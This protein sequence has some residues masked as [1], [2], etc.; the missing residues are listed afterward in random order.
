MAQLGMLF[1]MG[2]LFALSY[3]WTGSLFAPVLLHSLNNVYALLQG[4]LQHQGAA[5]IGWPAI[6]L[7]VVSPLIAFAILYVLMRVLP[8]KKIGI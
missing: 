2:V 5:P 7:A 3:E 6:V 4:V 8:R 1:F